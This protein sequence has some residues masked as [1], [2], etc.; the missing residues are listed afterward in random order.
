M[1]WA[2]FCNWVIGSRRP[3]QPKTKFCPTFFV[4]L[5]QNNNTRRR[6]TAK[7]KKEMKKTIILAC[8]CTL[9]SINASKAEEP[10]Q[11]IYIDKSCPASVSVNTMTSSGSSS[12]ATRTENNSTGYDARTTV[13]DNNG[14]Q[15]TY[16]TAPQSAT[17]Q[18]GGSFHRGSSNG[19]KL[20]TMN[21]GNN[22]NVSRVD[23]TCSP[24]ER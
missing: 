7:L 16:H 21:I 19:G 5:S 10:K 9:C 18:G 1:T 23:V 20:S 11:K 4:C 22:S 3:Q 2:L 14:Y 13:T 12:A 24:V 17:E 8:V 6:G 15:T